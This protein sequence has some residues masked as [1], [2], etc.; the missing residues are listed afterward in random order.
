[1]GISKETGKVIKVVTIL[2]FISIV[3]TFFY[4]RNQN[5]SE[6]P[7]VVPA[8][9][10]YKQFQETSETNDFDK[11]FVMLDS[12]ENIYSIIPHYRNSY[13]IGVLNNNRSAIFLTISLYQSIDS[14]Q[15]AEGFEKSIFFAEKSIGIYR[16]WF[17][18][19]G[20][21]DDREIRNE[22]MKDF[23]EGL[24]LKKPAIEKIVNKRIKE[25]QEAKYETKRRLSVSYTNLGIAF[26][27]TNRAEEAAECY[28]VALTFWDRNFSAKNNLNILLDRPLEEQSFMDK[29]FPPDK[30]EE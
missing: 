18:K 5:R 29:M 3:V 7:R 21:L 20:N 24:Q 17:D 4:Y 28:K 25:I 14:A 8:K 26:R 10:L 23:T 16:E 15:K 12:I 27:H 1:M 11:L 13:E 9:V 6:D 30:K 22:L 2:V 19:F